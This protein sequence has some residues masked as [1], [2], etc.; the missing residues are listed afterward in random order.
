MMDNVE[1]SI[2]VLIYQH[3]KL[4]ENNVLL[5]VKSAILNSSILLSSGSGKKIS[6]G[7]F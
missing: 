5:S 4:L 2:I 7:E 6:C 3:H 1:R